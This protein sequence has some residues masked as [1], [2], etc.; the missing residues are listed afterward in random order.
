MGAAEAVADEVE[1]VGQAF[2]EHAGRRRADEI[3]QGPV[4]VAVVEEMEGTPSFETGGSAF[5]GGGSS[6]AAATG[7]SRGFPPARSKRLRRRG[8]RR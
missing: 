3:E 1:A 5:H 2:A 6:A 7:A 8:S 4:A